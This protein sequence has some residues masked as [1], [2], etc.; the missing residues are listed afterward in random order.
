MAQRKKHSP[1]FKAQVAL[2]AV[3]GEQTL[4]EL[5][6]QYNLELGTLC[7]QLYYVARM[8]HRRSLIP[9]PVEHPEGTR[10]PG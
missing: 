6:S 10:F 4:A 7:C 2:E 1:N 3:K 9:R 5:A 8:E